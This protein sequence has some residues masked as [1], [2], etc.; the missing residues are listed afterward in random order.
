MNKRYRE[1]ATTLQTEMQEEELQ[2]LCSVA[3]GL[4][5][6]ERIAEIGT[7][8][9]G[10]LVHLL[11]ALPQLPPNQVVVVDKFQ[12]F[13]NHLGIWT[14]NIQSHG[15]Q[16]NEID[17]RV[18]SS[19]EGFMRSSQAGEQFSLILVDA[20]HKLKDVIRDVR[21]LSRLEVG[22]VGAFHDYSEKF[23]GV[24]KAVDVFLKRNSNYVI[25]KQAGTLLFVRKT[26]QS[27]CDEMPTHIIWGMTFLSL[28]MQ[29]QR[30]LKKRFRT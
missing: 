24:Q 27:S 29:W 30:S 26:E 13:D 1:S 2:A 16:P 17:V 7:A 15:F 22:G 4:S 19:E 6:P 25:E 5:N 18:G 23:P 11:K 10:T 20:G 12:Y 14:E 3:E 9:G 28:L 21:W 8:A